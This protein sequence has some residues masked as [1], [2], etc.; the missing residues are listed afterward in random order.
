MYNYSN[1]LSGFLEDLDIS[2]I[3]SPMNPLRSPN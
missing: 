1:E 2:D 3:T